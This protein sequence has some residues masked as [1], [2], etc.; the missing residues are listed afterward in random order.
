MI[1][2]GFW[3]FRNKKERCGDL[4]AKLRRQGDRSTAR[5]QFCGSRLRDQKRQFGGTL[6]PHLRKASRTAF[7]EFQHIL[8]K[9]LLTFATHLKKI[10][11]EQIAKLCLKWEAARKGPA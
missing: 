11:K 3:I 1:S 7:A 10:D 2:Y 6:V 9:I 4:L 8:Q 5:F